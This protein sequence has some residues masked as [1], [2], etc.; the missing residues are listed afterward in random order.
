V[1]QPA[2]RLP[3]GPAANPYP[4]LSD[5]ARELIPRLQVIFEEEGV[6]GKWVWLAEVESAFNPLAVSRKGAGGCFQLMP[7][8]AQRFGLRVF[9]MD[10]RMLPERSARAAARYLNV[11][12]RE[13]GSWSLA[14]AAY[15]AGEGTVNRA[16]V[17]HA[18]R[19]YADIA[20]VLPRET[21]AYVPRVMA[22]AALRE[23]QAAGVRAACWMP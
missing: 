15:N 17:R 16:L 13:F 14:L 8:T 12:Y 10:D 18:G 21:Q 9:P 22:A 1:D 7:V 20:A 11:L 2:Y 23:D 4:K 3:A 5:R 19:C 6:P